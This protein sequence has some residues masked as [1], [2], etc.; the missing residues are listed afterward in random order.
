MR[1][2]VVGIADK[3]LGEIYKHL[4][5]LPTLTSLYRP[6]RT[7]AIRPQVEGAVVWTCRHSSLL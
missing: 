6:R 4:V 7:G 3:V 5:T 2:H 1:V